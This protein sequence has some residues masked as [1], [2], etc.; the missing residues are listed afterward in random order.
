MIKKFEEEKKSIDL[1]KA[2]ENITSNAN[3]KF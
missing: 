2:E 1:Q 3:M